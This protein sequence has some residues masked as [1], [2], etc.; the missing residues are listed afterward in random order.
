MVIVILATALDVSNQLVELIVRA[1]Q[2]LLQMRDHSLIL[3]ASNHGQILL[4]NT[5]RHPHKLFA[6]LHHLFNLLFISGIVLLHRLNVTH[7]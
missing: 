7:V 1:V 4:V 2:G 6:F 5:R 3:R